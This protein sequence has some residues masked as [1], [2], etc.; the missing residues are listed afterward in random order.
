LG[1]S[2]VV[3]ILDG[4]LTTNPDGARATFDVPFA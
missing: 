4:V 1:S 3:E 2:V